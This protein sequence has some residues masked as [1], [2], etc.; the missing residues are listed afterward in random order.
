MGI[1]APATSIA[2]RP[3]R[4]TLS[5]PGELVPDGSGGWTQEDA[6]L[7]PPTRQCRIQPATVRDLEQL[8]SNPTIVSQ[9]TAV[10]TGPYR[11][12][13]TTETILQ[14]RGATYRVNGIQSPDELLVDT[15][16]FCTK[17][18]AP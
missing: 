16:L 6:P 11:A 2:A 4:V 9:A 14:Y 3:H 8:T 13:I 7:S 15:V 18:S 5:A 12:D 1:L 17:Q 10:I